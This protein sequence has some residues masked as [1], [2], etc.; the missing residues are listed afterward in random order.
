MGIKISRFKPW[1]AFDSRLTTSVIGALFLIFMMAIATFQIMRGQ[2][3]M[4]LASLCLVAMC[5]CY[6]IG[7]W[8]K[9]Y[10][11]PLSVMTI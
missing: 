3:L 8:M 10:E 7:R 11:R 9:Q 1:K 4:G 2:L 6:M 5:I